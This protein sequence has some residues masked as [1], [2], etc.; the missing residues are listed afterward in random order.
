VP[1]EEPSTASI[2]EVFSAK[3]AWAAALLLGPQ[4]TKNLGLRRRCTELRSIPRLTSPAFAVNVEIDWWEKEAKVPY[5]FRLTTIIPASPQEIY[6]AWLDKLAHSEMTGS[7]AITSDELGAEVS[8]WD[9]YISGRNLE[10]V[11]GER[12]VQS[13]RTTEFADEHE[14]SIISLLLEEVDD[15]TLLTLVHTNVPDGQTSYEQ[16]GWQQYYFEPMQ[17]HFS[18][19]RRAGLAKA[20]AP[21]PK[22]KTKRAAA[23]TKASAA[24]GKA[25]TRKKASAAAKAKSKHTVGAKRKPSSRTSARGSRRR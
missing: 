10:L 8:A 22:T 12:I 20:K 9:G 11:P 17:R 2:P 7:E 25:A 23:K 4:R 21:S 6:D 13:W 16:R 18:K 19:A 5:D 15:G 14:D 3:R 1:V 24:K